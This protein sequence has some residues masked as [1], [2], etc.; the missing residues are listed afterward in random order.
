MEIIVPV[1]VYAFKAAVENLSKNNH[2]PDKQPE[3]TETA[4]D[5]NDIDGGGVMGGGYWYDRKGTAG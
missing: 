2:W 1:A 3:D 5:R 4:P